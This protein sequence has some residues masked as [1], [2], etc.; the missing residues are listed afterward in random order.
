[1]EDDNPTASTTELDL[2]YST[3]LGLHA[4]IAAV[5]A[6]V[7][8]WR[9]ETDELYATNERLRMALEEIAHHP[10]HYNDDGDSDTAQAM[11]EIARRAS[12]IASTL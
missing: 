6:Q 9:R 2:S 12:N 11:R 1:M 5:K 10:S 7:E 4:E 3:V 8:R